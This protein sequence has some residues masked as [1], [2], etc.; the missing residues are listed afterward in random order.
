MKELIDDKY[1]KKICA[2]AFKK[3]TPEYKK[4]RPVMPFVQK[5]HKDKL[6]VFECDCKDNPVIIDIL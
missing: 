5:I 6:M 1:K 2:V 3:D 4:F